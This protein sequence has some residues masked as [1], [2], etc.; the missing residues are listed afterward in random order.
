MSSLW[1]RNGL[2]ST[3]TKQ[4]TLGMNEQTDETLNMPITFTII[5]LCC[6]I[7]S[8]RVTD[9]QHNP[10]FFFDTLDYSRWIVQIFLD[11]CNPAALHFGRPPNLEILLLWSCLPIEFALSRRSGVLATVRA[12]TNASLDV[13][14]NW[15]SLEKL[16]VN[17]ELIS[18]KYKAL[19]KKHKAKWKKTFGRICVGLSRLLAFSI[20]IWEDSCIHLY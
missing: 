8:D 20:S 10:L 16:S 17:L 5:S 6:F 2:M 19:T 18:F 7:F 14:W 12:R 3:K 15:K 13:L 11:H 9:N 1:Q 4:I